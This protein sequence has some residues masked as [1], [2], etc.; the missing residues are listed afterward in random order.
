MSSPVAQ[1]AGG[2]G[3]GGQGLQSAPREIFADI[4]QEKE[5]REKG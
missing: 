4:Y 2:G 1:Q 5:A 3:G